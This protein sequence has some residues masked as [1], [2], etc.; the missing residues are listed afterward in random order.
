MALEDE[1]TQQFEGDFQ[2]EYIQAVH[3]TALTLMGY[4]KLHRLFKGLLEKIAGLAN[5]NYAFLYFTDFGGQNHLLLQTQESHIKVGLDK[6]VEL[7]SGFINK[8]WQS[9]LPTI[10]GD[11]SLISEICDFATEPFLMSAQTLIA[12]PLKSNQQVF[13]VAGLWNEKAGQIYGEYEMLIL[14]SFANLAIL[15]FNN[16][17]YTTVPS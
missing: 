11:Y 15:A 4:T 14:Q 9:G 17:R 6:P 5:T 13:G 16:I 2:R 3:E 1:K 7:A 10:C 12:V 8:V